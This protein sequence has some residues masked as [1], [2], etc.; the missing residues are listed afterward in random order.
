MFVRF[1][2]YQICVRGVYAVTISVHG[3]STA[4]VQH[5]PC[6][7]S[8]LC[9]SSHGVYVGGWCPDCRISNHDNIYILTSNATTKHIVGPHTRHTKHTAVATAVALRIVVT[10]M[11]PLIDYSSDAPDISSQPRSAREPCS[12]DTIDGSCYLVLW[13]S[14]FLIDTPY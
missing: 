8:C 2:T 10:P 3:S 13:F 5:Q 4:A 12:Y 6:S 7:S 1:C 11:F 14:C 9:A